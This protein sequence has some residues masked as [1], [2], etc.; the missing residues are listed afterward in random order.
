MHPAPAALLPVYGARPL[1]VE[2][3]EGCYLIDPQGRRYL[4]FIT[5]IGVNALGHNH[6]AVVGALR[7]QAG[8]CIHTSNIHAHRYQAELATRLAEWSGL[9]LVFFSNSG[10]EAMEAALKAAR[11][12]ANSRGRTRHRIVAL[13]NS[14]HGRTAAALAVTGR[15]QYRAAVPAAHSGRGVRPRQR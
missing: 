13:E 9:D 5:G 12:L 11:A 3:G 10:T 4:D 1:M 15:P 8:L 6:P 7:E 2:R 14:F